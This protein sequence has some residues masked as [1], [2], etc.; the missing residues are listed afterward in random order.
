[1]TQNTYSV[2]PKRS[3]CLK[4]GV[5]ATPASRPS[6]SGDTSLR[7]GF[8]AP[9][10][11]SVLFRSLAFR[12]YPAFFPG[13]GDTAVA[14]PSRCVREAHKCST[15]LTRVMGPSR[16]QSEAFPPTSSIRTPGNSVPPNPSLNRTLCLLCALC[17]P[18]AKRRVD[19]QFWSVASN[20]VLHFTHVTHCNNA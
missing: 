18:V 19:Y 20:P 11:R 15:V 6:E 12:L 14:R 5:Q 3:A 4:P 17:A 8:A 10:R 16:S 7:T 13:I 1:M 2:S 9:A